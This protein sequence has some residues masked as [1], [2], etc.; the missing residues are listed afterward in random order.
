MDIGKFSSSLLTS[1]FHFIF[2]KK[3]LMNLLQ[4]FYK[5][6]VV[7]SILVVNAFANVISKVLSLRIAIT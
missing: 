7:L 1:C 5:F 6:G 2:F 3:K 4:V